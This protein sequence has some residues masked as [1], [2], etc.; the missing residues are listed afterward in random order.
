MMA[1]VELVKNGYD[2][3]ARR[4]EV[5][6]ENTANTADIQDGLIS[7]RDDG[8]GMDLQTVLYGWMEPA[9]PRKRARGGSKVRTPLGRIQLG[10]KGVGRFAADK[11]GSELELVTR[12]PGSPDEIVL[13]VG[14][15][16]YDH[17]R[18]LDEVENVWFTRDP[19]EFPGDA[20]GTLLLI[21]DLR[22][23]WDEEMMTRLYSGLSRLVSPAAGGM[24]FMIDLRCPDFPG[25]SGP[26]VNRLVESAPYRLAGQIDAR[27]VLHAETLPE[28]VVDLLPLCHGHFAGLAGEPRLPVCGPFSVTLN[29][30]DLEPS[31]GRGFGV[32]RW[33]R[34]RIK[35]ASGVSVYRDG[36]RVWPYGEKDDDWLELNQ[37]RV[38]NPTLRISNNQ[39]IGY[40][41]ITHSD[42]ADLRDRTSREGL[43]DTPAFF[44]LKVLVLAA[45]SVLETERFARRRIRAA[46]RSPV[47]GEEDDAVLQTLT[48]IR[49]GAG[50]SDQVPGLRSA[51]QELDRL[52]RGQL[53]QERARYNQVS[54]LAGVGMAAELL[55]DTFSRK[56][57][58][59]T[60]LLRTLQGESRT[61]ASPQIQ[62]L[63]RDLATQLEDL[64][65]QVDM[66]GPL[67]RPSTQDN[68]PVSLRG[69]VYDVATIFAGQ[70][71]ETGTRLMLEGPR[72]LSVRLNRGHLMQV[73]MILIHNALQAMQESAISDPRIVV[74][75]IRET[76]WSGIRIMDNGPGVPTAVRNLIFEPYFSTRQ[77]GRGLGLHVARDILAGYNSAIELVTRSAIL[78]G[79]CFE[80]RFDGRRLASESTD[81]H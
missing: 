6:I 75:V 65:E 53:V 3:D 77:A 18:Y 46:S 80:V 63:I 36:F 33:L 29:V 71:V 50:R 35:G 32:D 64:N 13:R 7:V 38:N 59:A 10:E 81:S 70:L 62:N 74:E 43:L 11:L 19:V 30:W 73:L 22:A 16:H 76:E 48:R 52:Y 68:H 24:D 42:N 60:T 69:V 47:E 5:L 23:R 41:E 28:R 51:L 1:V 56:V 15:H 61:G 26:V 45:L 31:T 44:D 37:R 55:T 57:L 49:A 54:R 4:V 2:A 67:Y 78:P 8:S 34:E 9:T 39:I 25:I 72:D 21:R 14:W 79:A 12:P 20:H 17:D 40:V 66:M 58:N 27:G